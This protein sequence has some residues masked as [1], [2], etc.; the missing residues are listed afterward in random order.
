MSKV[1]FLLESGIRM[2]SSVEPIEKV[3]SHYTI[4]VFSRY[5]DSF[6]S[7]IELLNPRFIKQFSFQITWHSDSVPFSGGKVQTYKRNKQL[8]ELASQHE[9]HIL[10]TGINEHLSI[11]KQCDKPKLL[12]SV[13]KSAYRFYDCSIF[14]Q[15]NT[16]RIAS[17]HRVLHGKLNLTGQAFADLVTFFPY[18]IPVSFATAPN[19]APTEHESQNY[20]QFFSNTPLAKQVIFPMLLDLGATQANSVY[21]LF[22]S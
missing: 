17:V 1:N 7:F 10:G 9:M 6:I 2:W 11:A 4:T 13:W 22:L 5:Y 18:C 19:T 14:F 15:D 3:D 12:D 16:P 21:E 20:I 8:Q